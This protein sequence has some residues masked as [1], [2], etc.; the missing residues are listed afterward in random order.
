M[1]SE[2]QNGEINS[3]ISKFNQLWHYGFDAHLDLHTHAGSAWVGLQVNLGTFAQPQYSQNKKAPSPSRQRR[4]RKRAAQ[5]TLATSKEATIVAD[6]NEIA[7]DPNPIVSQPCADS[8]LSEERYTAEEVI[9][10]SFAGSEMI[11]SQIFQRTGSNVSN[12]RHS[13][14]TSYLSETFYRL[15][16]NLEF[17]RE[18]D[19][20]QLQEDQTHTEP[21]VFYQRSR[22]Q[23]WSCYTDSVLLQILFIIILM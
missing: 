9:E 20:S 19:R 5:R 7:D 6:E 23:F 8:T 11:G 18:Q 17:K 12:S 21:T 14:E 16:R 15:I 13:E 1:Y 4:W 2:I 3:F 22:Y 10:E